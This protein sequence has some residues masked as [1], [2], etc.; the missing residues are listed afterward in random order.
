LGNKLGT[1]MLLKVW[2]S[3]TKEKENLGKNQCLTP[4]SLEDVGRTK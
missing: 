1:P 3:A 2:S 4:K